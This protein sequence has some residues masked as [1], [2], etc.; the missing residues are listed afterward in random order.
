[1]PSISMKVSLAVVALAVASSASADSIQVVGGWASTR[2]HRTDGLEDPSLPFVSRHAA[3][4]GLRGTLDWGGHGLFEAEARWV[5]RGGGVSFR[6]TYGYFGDYLELAARPAWRTGRRTEL[7]VGAG[8]AVSLRLRNRTGASLF[9][10]PDGENPEFGALKSTELAVVA[11]TGVRFRSEGSFVASLQAQYSFGLTGVHEL[12]SPG[13]FHDP[14]VF[15]FPAK[16]RTLSILV[17]IGLGR[18]IVP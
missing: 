14:H 18:K 6:Q 10:G 13:T 12:G 8:P 11:A 17:G 15:D 2:M 3:T 9:S 1:M 7:S 16:S 4:L 5:P